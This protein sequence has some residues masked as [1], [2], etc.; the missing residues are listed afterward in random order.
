MGSVE[1]RTDTG[2]GRGTTTEVDP[3]RVR[4]TNRLVALLRNSWRQLTSMRTALILLFLLAVAAIPG[5]VLPQRNISPEKVDE[6][7]R[8][9]PDLAPVLDR[10]GGFDVFASIWFSAIYLLLFTSLVGCIVPRMRDHVR[11]LR[12]VPPAGPKR[13]DR[14]PQHAVLAELDGT[15]RQAVAEAGGELPAIAAMLRKRR[16]RVA[17]HGDTVAAEKG[18]LKESGNL[19]FHISLLA[20]LVAVALGSWYGWHGNRLLVAG[21]DHSF[22][23][24]IDQFSESG[25]GP[26][27]RDTDLPGFCLELTNFKA[28]FLPSG[29]PESFSAS[30]LV[31]EDG[32]A[33]RPADF[34]VNSPLRLNGASVYLLGHG[35]APV[36]RYTDRNGKSITVTSPFLSNDGNLTS[37]GVATFPDVNLDPKTGERDPKLQVAFEGIYLPTAPDQPPFVR[38]QFPSERN[39]ALMLIAY[40]GNLGLDAGLPGSVYSLNQKLIREGRL[41]Q[42]GEAKLLRPNESWTLD[43]GTKVEFLGTQQYITLSV[44]HAP[45]STLMLV[46][47]VLLLIG[48]MFALFS[49]RRRVWF[50]V[51]PA[52]PENGSTTGGSSLV[53]AGGLPRTDYAGFADEF[54]QLVAA[55]K[56]GAGS[57]E[58]TE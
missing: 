38:S 30:V 31:D 8:A 29:Q 21:K 39:P 58:G 14:L 24:T 41:T 13:M 56:R 54:D 10:I 17:V 1:E 23:S 6:Y 12:S 42:V 22:C 44:R 37:E 51:T 55:V 46:S 52:A 50:R 15:G 5:S 18:Y 49:R 25:L 33:Q 27:V 2:A 57:R 53:E 28:R 11:T 43:D 26:R 7:F 32:G 34:S 48:L 36:I 9:H 19:L 20:M 45:A 3:P 4:G 35:Y 16:W 40:R 47:S